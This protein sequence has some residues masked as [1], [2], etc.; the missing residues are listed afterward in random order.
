MRRLRK[1]SKE[2][3]FRGRYRNYLGGVNFSRAHRA[4]PTREEALGCRL[5]GRP[6]RPF[7]N[8]IQ[9]DSCTSSFPPMPS[10][11]ILSSPNTVLFLSALAVWLCGPGRPVLGGH[12]CGRR[13]PGRPAWPAPR[14]DYAMLK[15]AIARLWYAIL[16]YVRYTVYYVLYNVYRTT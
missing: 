11:T 5:P 6:G 3:G 7:L 13:C 14:G 12:G 16:R 10:V 8:K 1:P 2:D 15:H 4:S 9:E